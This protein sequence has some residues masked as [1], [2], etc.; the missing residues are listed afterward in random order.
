MYGCALHDYLGKCSQVSVENDQ[1][2]LLNIIASC[3]ESNN[4]DD[5]LTSTTVTTS[6][7]N[8]PPA[9]HSFYTRINQLLRSKFA[10]AAYRLCL[11]EES[12]DLVEKIFS[13]IKVAPIESLH[14]SFH[15]TRQFK[16]EARI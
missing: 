15:G 5:D 3:D 10:I 11:E 4:K 14:L 2:W 7:S 8:T 6:T 13:A 1:I 16:N 12:N 9:S